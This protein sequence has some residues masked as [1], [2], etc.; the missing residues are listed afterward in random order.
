MRRNAPNQSLCKEVS[1]GRQHEQFRVSAGLLT[2]SQQEVKQLK[3]FNTWTSAAAWCTPPR[4]CLPG[5]QRSKLPAC[6][7]STP[8]KP[9]KAYQGRDQL[10]PHELQIEPVAGKKN[11]T[12]SETQ[13]TMKTKGCH[14]F[15]CKQI[16]YASTPLDTGPH[17]HESMLDD[18][19]LCQDLPAKDC[20][21]LKC[22]RAFEKH[23][24]DVELNLSVH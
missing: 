16:L 9:Q 15:G 5:L 2:A 20:L 22:G 23:P 6:G 3:S 1:I 18:S 4:R 10:D 13:G 24:T 8:P 7:I 11:E 21:W 19:V 12:W 17:V 14:D